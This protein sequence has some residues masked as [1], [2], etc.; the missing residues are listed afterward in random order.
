ME[1][2]LEAHPAI[3]HASV[4]G[5]DDAVRGRVVVAVIQLNAPTDSA[6][7][8]AMHL[9]H[10]CHQRLE[11]YKAPRHYWVCPDWPLTAAAKPDHRALGHALA[12]LGRGPTQPP[13]PCLTPLP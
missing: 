8:Q 7:V 4:H 10:W 13:L 9:T 2:V 1:T 5:V 12:A 11:P 6:T 3:A